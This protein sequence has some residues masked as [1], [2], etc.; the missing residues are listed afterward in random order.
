MN[1]NA[2]ESGKHCH[3]NGWNGGIETDHVISEKERKSIKETKSIKDRRIEQERRS[4]K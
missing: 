4:E 1:G 3:P 2:K